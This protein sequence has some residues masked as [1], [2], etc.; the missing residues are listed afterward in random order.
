MGERS[1][2]T[3]LLESQEGTERTR[4]SLRH[5]FCLKVRSSI[6]AFAMESRLAFY[7]FDV[8]RARNF[9]SHCVLARRRSLDVACTVRNEAMSEQYWRK[10]RT[11]RFRERLRSMS[12]ER[13]RSRSNSRAGRK[14]ALSMEFAAGL[15]TRL[16]DQPLPLQVEE[17]RRRRKIRI[18]DHF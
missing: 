8:F 11:E 2:K 13:S 18:M 10:E 15:S 14:R 17:G 4:L 1:L 9:Y 16:A 12:R 3:A 6:S 5:S 7:L